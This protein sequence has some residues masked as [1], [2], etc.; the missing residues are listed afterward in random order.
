SPTVVVSSI[1][2]TPDRAFAVLGTPNLF[3]VLGVSPSMGRPF[4]LADAEIGAARVAIVSD[5]LWRRL[6]GAD[7][8]VVGRQILIDEA[9]TQIIG[10]MPPAVEF[11]NRATELWLPLRLSR[12]QP[13]NPAI[14]PERYRQYRILSL[15]GRL[16][17]GASLAMARAEV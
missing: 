9:R 13:P 12:T 11:P 6:F 16:N 10:V 1:G 17:P 5:A 3:E 7:P 4:T 2:G 15:A 8:S 14:P